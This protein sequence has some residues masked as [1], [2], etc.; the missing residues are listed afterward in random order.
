MLGTDDIPTK[1]VKYVT[2]IISPVL[3]VIYNLCIE[4]GVFPD[5][6]KLAIIKP[7]FE[8]KDKEDINCYRPEA[9]LPVFSKIFEKIFYDSF[10]TY[11]ENKLGFRK[12][13]SI[14]FLI[15]S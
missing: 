8:K 10:I 9:L 3:T 4:N 6:L 2:H 5:N 11:F 7:L 13:K 1:V 14:K 15:G 12:N